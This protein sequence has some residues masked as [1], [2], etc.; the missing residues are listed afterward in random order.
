MVVDL[1]TSKPGQAPP[2]EWALPGVTDGADVLAALC[3]RH[4]Q[5]WPGDTFTARTR[6]G[7][8]HLYFT[9]PP[10]LRLRTTAGDSAG[11]LGW[12]IDTRGHGGYVVAPGSTVTLPDGT[13]T[14]EVING[15]APAVLPGWLARLLTPADPA[16]PSLGGRPMLPDLVRDLDTYAATA[17]KGESERVR[18]AA[19]GGRNRALNKAA[20][21]LGRLI[22]VGALP[23]NL[24][25]A[26]LQAAASVHF[27]AAPPLTPAEAHATITAGLAAGKRRP[28]QVTS[29]AA[30]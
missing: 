4:G 23:E 26:E 11:G 18:T 13:G 27:G 15:Q 29:G 16:P 12:L 3:E 17:L 5:P 25:R 6:R 21:M 20:Y 8:L 7:G 19:P 9:A 10:G 24:V 30:A 22:A 28:R 2:P 1:D 14:Y